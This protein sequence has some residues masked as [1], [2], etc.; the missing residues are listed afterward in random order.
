MIKKSVVFSQLLLI[1]LVTLTLVSIGNASTT[2]WFISTYESDDFVTRATEE[3]TSKHYFSQ[4]DPFVYVIGNVT[5]PPQ[6][7][8]IIEVKYY[9]GGADPYNQPPIDQWELVFTDI[10]TISPKRDWR[11]IGGEYEL[12]YISRMPIAGTDYASKTYQ[13]NVVV[14]TNDEVTGTSFEISGN[15]LD[16]SSETSG[17]SDGSEVYYALITGINAPSSIKTGESFQVDVSFDYRFDSNV[18]FNPA[19]YDSST[20]ELITEDYFD[21]VSG[22]GSDIVSFSIIAPDNPGEYEFT[23][24]LY[25]ELE[26]EYYYD[27]AGIATYPITISSESGSSGTPTPISGDDERG[28]PG[29]P[30]LA[31]GLGLLITRFIHRRSSYDS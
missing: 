15:D 1:I 29:F 13:W 16:Q 4:D 6:D 25:F 23:I 17:S 20:E 31:V 21:D 28:I 22:S 9:Y 14:T 19:I 18:V 11:L 8:Y 10:A 12:Q 5:M 3:S 27:D 7:E 26:G 30:Y 2:F 24:V